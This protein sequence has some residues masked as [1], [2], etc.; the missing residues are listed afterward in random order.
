MDPSLP[1]QL[2]VQGVHR[3]HGDLV[4]LAGVDLAVLPGQVHGLLGPNGAGKSTL[5]R[6]VFGLALPDAGTVEVLGRDPALEPPAGLA[7]FV[8][9]PRFYPHLSGRRNL[10]LLGAYDGGVTAEELT[11]VLALT[12]LTDR[13][14][15]K[16]RGWSTGMR[17]RLALAAALL[18]RPQL[19]VLDEPT[20]GLD[21][22]GMRDLR[23]LIRELAATGTGVLLA[24]H[25]MSDADLLCDEVTI[26]R[27]GKVALAGSLPRLRLEAPA[28]GARLRTDDDAAAQALAGRA[29]LSVEPHPRGGWQLRADQRQLDALMV[30]LGRA[31]IAV[32][33]LMAD[34]TPLEALYWAATGSSAAGSSA[35]E[36]AA[37]D[38]ADAAVAAR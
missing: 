12:D 24:S 27:A 21:P 37:Q 18:R 13:A 20:V 29:G 11:R 36:P 26:L 9:Q 22:A 35:L 28:A 38:R 5:L 4:A 7:G 10:E 19:L 3:S 30:E 23:V 33:E 8:D 31:G 14:G 15:S 6:L 2:L 16:V 34:V 25:D 32:R 17:Q 1:A